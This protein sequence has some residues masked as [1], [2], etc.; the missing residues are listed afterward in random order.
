M[1]MHDVTPATTGMLMTGRVHTALRPLPG[2]TLT[3]VDR[4]GVQMG[5]ART[6]SGGEFQVI[7]LT[8]GSYVVIFS[9]AGY[10]P[11]AEVVMLG[12]GTQPLDVM[13]EP[14]VGVHGVVHDRDSGR[15]VGA[16]TVTALDPG[17]EVIAST[18]SDPEGS[19]HI[20]GIDADAITLLV[21]VPGADPTATVVGLGRGIDYQADLALD[22]YSAVSGT[23][24]M[25]GK[26]VER[27]PLALHAPDGWTVATT[28]TDNHGAYRFDRVKAGQY[29]LASVTSTGRT[30]ALAPDATTADLGLST[31]SA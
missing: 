5:R 10:Q 17:G 6:G 25:D 24:T 8:P 12:A 18:V 15:P 13:L 19:Y 29:V 9:R 26:P 4:A 11:K 30:V 2:T 1:T 14:A 16:A 28:V 23:V 21:A 22:T 27:L 3:L 7:G 31:R 20:T